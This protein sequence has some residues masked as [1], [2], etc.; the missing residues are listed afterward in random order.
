MQTDPTA[1]HRLI[2]SLAA[3]Q[4]CYGAAP[5]GLPSRAGQVPYGN[6]EQGD[7][8]R[9]RAAFGIPSGPDHLM[10]FRMVVCPAAR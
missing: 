1:C 3:L 4:R 10:V 2:G 8:A 9:C 6:N 7:C 5:T